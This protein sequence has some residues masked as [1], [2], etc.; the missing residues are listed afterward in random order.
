MYAIYYLLSMDYTDIL[1]IKILSQSQIL[2]QCAHLRSFHL[3]FI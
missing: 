2:F 3:T 1:Y